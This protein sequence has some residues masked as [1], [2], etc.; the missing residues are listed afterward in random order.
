MKKKFVSLLLCLCLIAPA[1]I[2]CSVAMR[3]KAKDGW[4]KVE[5][6]IGPLLE[7][8]EHAL[9]SVQ[10]N[11][12]FWSALVQGTLQ[13][14]GVNITKAQIDAAKPVIAAVDS[15]LVPLGAATTNKPVDPVAVQNAIIAVDTAVPALTQQALAN[16][17]VNALY[18]AYLAGKTNVSA[19]AN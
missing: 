6:V 7:S 4:A 1:G 18:Q 2:G 9:A 12:A 5:R 14:V 3:Q 13:V 8:A 11:Y 17:A 19:P 16:P 15:V 10:K